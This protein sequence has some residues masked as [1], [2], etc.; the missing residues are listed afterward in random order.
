[1]ENY[2]PVLTLST[3]VSQILLLIVGAFFKVE[4]ADIKLFEVTTLKYNF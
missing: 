4:T 1:M 3:L 2:A